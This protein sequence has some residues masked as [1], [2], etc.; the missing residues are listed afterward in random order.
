MNMTLLLEVET[1]CWFSL[2]CPADGCGSGVAAM[3]NL[4]FGKPGNGPASDIKE[5]QS[6]SYKNTSVTFALPEEDGKT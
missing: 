3:T 1:A 6:Q 5:M 4:F 2:A